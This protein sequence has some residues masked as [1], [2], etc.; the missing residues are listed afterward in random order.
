MTSSKVTPNTQVTKTTPAGQNRKPPDKGKAKP[1]GKIK[2]SV[3]KMTPN[4]TTTA[5]SSAHL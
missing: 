2:K 4:S 1:Q 5:S 3:A